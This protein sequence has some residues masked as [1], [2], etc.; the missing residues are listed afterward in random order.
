MAKSLDMCHRASR[1][2]PT[3]L[4]YLDALD[5]FVRDF[6]TH[7]FLSREEIVFEL[8]VYKIYKTIYG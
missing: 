3:E 8:K 2:L 1:A 4:T 5:F 7:V 6:L